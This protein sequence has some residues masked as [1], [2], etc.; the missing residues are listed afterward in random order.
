MLVPQ[1]VYQQ[2]A[3]LLFLLLSASRFF[4]FVGFQMLIDKYAIVHHKVALVARIFIERDDGILVVLFLK[5]HTNVL[6]VDK[7]GSNVVSP[8]RIAFKIFRIILIYNNCIIGLFA[9]GTLLVFVQMSQSQMADSAHIIVA[10]GKL[11]PHVRAEF[12]E[13]NQAGI[14]P[15]SLITHICVNGLTFYSIHS[16]WWDLIA[17]FGSDGLK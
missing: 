3:W 16:I 8:P 10:T 15:G 12:A 9:N 13:A 17:S 1:V 6:L 2:S 7:T 11:C 5:E 14:G 4:I